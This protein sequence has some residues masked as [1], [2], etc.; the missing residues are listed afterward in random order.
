MY[1]EFFDLIC[2]RIRKGEIK[3]MTN[4]KCRH[5]TR[6]KC[7]KNIKSEK[8]Q[9]FEEKSIEKKQ[10]VRRVSSNPWC[11]A[12]VISCKHHLR[13]MYSLKNTTFEKI[14]II[15]KIQLFEK[16][17]VWC[18]LALIHG[19]K[20]QSFPASE[21]HLPAQALLFTLQFHFKCVFVFLYFYL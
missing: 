16:Y 13:K 17:Q 8:I 4:T 19:V 10:S 21:H 14:Q 5:K 11:Q 9:N 1:S 7:V 3:S 6:T 18:V 15:R 2:F 12:A 20:Q